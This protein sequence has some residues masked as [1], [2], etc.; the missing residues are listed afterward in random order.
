MMH[1]NSKT[2]YM[3]LALLPTRSP[4]WLTQCLLLYNFRNSVPHLMAVSRAMSA[5]FNFQSRRVICYSI[6]RVLQTARN[7]RTLYKVR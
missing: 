2:T 5:I 4:T 6:F 3:D 7:D 1:F